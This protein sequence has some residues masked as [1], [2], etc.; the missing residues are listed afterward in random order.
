MCANLMQRVH[1]LIQPE[2]EPEQTIPIPLSAFRVLAHV[3][4]QMA[5][6]NGVSFTPKDAEWTTYEA[7]RVLKVSHPFLLGLLENGE[8]PFR[9]V[10]ACPRIRYEDLMAYKQKT[11]S[12]EPIQGPRGTLGARSGAGAGLSRVSDFTMTRSSPNRCRAAAIL[13]KEDMTPGGCS[14]L[15]SNQAIGEKRTTC[16]AASSCCSR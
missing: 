4:T 8:G 15:S 11:G 13:F 9:E 10:K 7:A 12:A 16:Q 14:M 1:V 5:H 2:N 3:L 6:G